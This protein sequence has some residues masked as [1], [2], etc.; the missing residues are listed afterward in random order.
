MTINR[1]IYLIITLLMC[2]VAG[3]SVAQKQGNIK[4]DRLVGGKNKD[5]ERYE[6]WI[7]NV[8]FVQE[9]TRIYCDSA[10]YYRSREVVEAFGDV[11][12]L[13]GDSVTITGRKLTYRGKEKKSTLLDDVVYKKDSITLYTDIL[14]YNLNSKV[15]DYIGGGRI[16]DPRNE[17]TSRIGT[18]FSAEDFMQFKDEVVL[19][20][21]EYTLYSDTLVYY[22]ETKVAD[23]RGA[24]RILGPDG[25]VN[26]EN[27]LL[28]R[29]SGKQSTLREGKVESESYV[30]SG[31]RLFSDELRNFYRANT[32]VQ[33]VSKEQDVIITGDEGRYWKDQGLT[34]IYGRAVMKKILGQDT[35][36]LSADTLVAIDSKVE[37]EKRV[38]A[39]PDVRIWKTNLQGRADSLAYYVA[40]SLIRFFEDPILWSDKNQIEGDSIWITLRDGG[41]ENMFVKQNSFVVSEDTLGNYNQVKGRNMVARFRDNAIKIVD[42]E[43]NGESIYF[44][45]EN[46]SI[47]TGM[48]KIICSNM[49]LFF[50]DNQLSKINFYVEPD[51]SF[52]PPHEIAAAQRT[53][54][55]FVWRIEKR[56]TLQDVL[57]RSDIAEE[58]EEQ[59]LPG[60]EFYEEEGPEAGA[61]NAELSE[62]EVEVSNND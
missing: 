41:I 54:P 23:F 22:T 15:A 28:Y 37:A 4:G 48:N 1:Y 16:V 42:V 12:I 27:G 24:T 29:T 34:K 52:F 32:D 61:S 38:L 62:K 21:D 20:N 51:A 57:L 17:L 5:G 25:T 18:F 46:D 40:D 2:L 58:E 39:Y 55:G 8:V 7:G 9:G 44:A 26:A 53:L 47:M 60:M 19:K 36:Y 13:D 35:V 33:L 6:K 43:G 56:P 59:T 11:R 45:L 10:L 14:N 50:E 31:L 49:R 3:Q 30:L